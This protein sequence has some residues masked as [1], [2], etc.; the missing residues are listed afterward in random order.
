MAWEGYLLSSN[1]YSG[2]IFKGWLAG[3]N[4]FINFLLFQNFGEFLCGKGKLTSSPF[5]IG[6]EANHIC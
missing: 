4:L 2:I 1:L 5:L 3:F 6:F